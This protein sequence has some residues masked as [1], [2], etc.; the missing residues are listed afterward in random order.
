MGASF[1]TAMMLATVLTGA[2]V[3]AASVDAAPT[4]N[5]PLMP[6]I[7]V[8]A[9]SAKP[10]TPD[11]FGTVALSAGVT[12]YDVRWRRVSGAD[13]SDPRVL[14]IAAVASGLDPYAMLVAIQTEVRRRVVWKRDIDGYKIYDYWAEAGETL[15]RGFGD[16]EDIA[17][18]GRDT[19]ILDRDDDLGGGNF[20]NAGDGADRVRNDIENGSVI[21][22][23]D[24]NG[25]GTADFQI[26]LSG[27]GAMLASDFLL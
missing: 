16:A 7:V 5:D 22:L 2:P 17:L 13:R 4:L 26:L 23:G 21:K 20:V 10:S 24:V 3:L 6:P 8:V 14:A 15:S 27:A 1:L 11:V 19:I 12:S 25:D 18:G 9:P